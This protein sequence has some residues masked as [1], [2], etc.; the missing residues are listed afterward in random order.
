ME[1][2]LFRIGHLGWVTEKEIKEVVAAIKAAMPR[3]GFAAAK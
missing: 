1:G 2:K 3:A